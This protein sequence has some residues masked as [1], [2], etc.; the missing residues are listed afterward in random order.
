MNTKKM[1]IILMLSIMALCGCAHHNKASIENEN[2]V[3][4]SNGNISTNNTEVYYC[5]IV[6]DSVSK[7]PELNT[8][9]VVIDEYGFGPMIVSPYASD[10]VVKAVA[11]VIYE[12]NIE[13]YCYG[14]YLFDKYSENFAECDFDEVYA[15]IQERVDEARIQADLNNNNLISSIENDSMINISPDGEYYY[16]LDM[17]NFEESAKAIQ[18]SIDK[19]S[20]VFDFDMQFY[21]EYYFSHEG[22]TFTGG[23]RGPT[24]SIYLNSYSTDNKIYEYYYWKAKNEWVDIYTD[25]YTLMIYDYTQ[26]GENLNSQTDNRK[27][28]TCSSCLYQNS[29]D[30]GLYSINYSY[31][32][33][34]DDFD[35]SEAIEFS[36]EVYTNVCSANGEYN[37]NMICGMYI[38]INNFTE[39]EKEYDS[40]YV[41][42]PF[43][44]DYSFDEFEKIITDSIE[45]KI[46]DEPV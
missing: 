26:I 30:T 27:K 37:T 20:D 2:S 28:L 13:A 21:C 14:N 34:S 10:D 3:S 16:I 33:Y 18:I 40:I 44:E 24:Y 43:E 4:N 29:Q 42:I 12:T 39:Y 45:M 19:Q 31:R 15:I 9:D 38:D 22:R 7:Y 1:S 35:L 36:Y 11:H 23:Y 25:L 5:D 41:F 46:E 32:M 6:N 17:D 8:I